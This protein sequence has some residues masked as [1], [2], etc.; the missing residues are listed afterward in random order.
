VTLL[1][2]GIVVAACWLS[3]CAGT[4]A[5]CRGGA[6]CESG[7]CRADGTCAPVE[8]STS[9][10]AGGSG[11]DG[12]SSG[13]GGSSGQG[14]S[15]LCAANDDGVIEQAEVPL[16]PGL[17][18]KYRVAGD[19]TVSTAGAPEGDGRRWDFTGALSGDHHTLFETIPLAGQWFEASFPGA[20]YAVRLTDAEDLLGVFEIAAGA[21][22]LRGVV[23]PE[24]GPSR[25]ELDF[26]PPVAVL[27]FPLEEGDAWLEETTVSG[28]AVGVV[29]FYT[30]TYDASVDAHGTVVAPFAEFPT[31]RVQIALERTV[32]LV[33]TLQR[34]QSWVAECFGPVAGAASQLGETS[35]DFDDVHE[36]RRLA[37]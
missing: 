22:L 28:V 26:D 21:L 14:G 5:E 4:R 11:G 16:G 37:P 17:G 12:G 3:G 13:G 29:S 32:G 18:A 9:P 10:G 8:G 20:T 6:D 25:T 15:G 7:A 35:P 23:S 19:V 30:E 1:R 31:L 33:T 36:L 27:R 2:C 34:T 24:G